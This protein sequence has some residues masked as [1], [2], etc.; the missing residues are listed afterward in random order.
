MVKM[1]FST[2]NISNIWIFF[3]IQ[4]IWLNLQRSMGKWSSHFYKALQGCLL[5]LDAL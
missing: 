5:T 3:Y 1:F 2:S 4:E